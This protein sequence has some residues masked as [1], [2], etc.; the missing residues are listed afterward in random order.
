MLTLRTSARLLALSA[1]V[2]TT[3]CGDDDIIDPVVQTARVRVVNL[4]P[5]AASAGLYANGTLLGTNV[6]FGSAGAQC[7]SVPIGQ[8]LTFRAS[9]QTT[10]LAT[11]QTSTLAANQSHTIV[12]Y[13]NGT[14]PQAAVL[15]DNNI[16]AP[17]TGNA[18]L[19]FFNAS[20][21]AGDIYLTSPG[22]ALPTTATTANLAAGQAT[23]TFGSY[24]TAN[25]QIRVF[26]AGSATTGTPVFTANVTP[27]NLSSTRIG[28]VFLT[29]ANATG[30]ANATL[31]TQPCS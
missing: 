17:T 6:A 18:A 27:T 22:G 10:N 31:T 13:A 19:R 4:N 29:N 16:T 2:L 14:T 20:G 8:A 3:A 24:P 7:V 28:N 25:T 12:L 1:A 9:G 5:N 11:V 30:G 23:A 15:S 26:N 21:T